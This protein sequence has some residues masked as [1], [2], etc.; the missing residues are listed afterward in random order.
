MKGVVIDIKYVEK[1]KRMELLW[2]I[3][4][5]IPYGIIGELFGCVAM[6][7]VVLQF[8]SILLLGKRVE[9]LNKV[10]HGFFAYIT[11]F[12]AYLYLLTDERPEIMPKI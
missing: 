9:I 2:R 1:T 5:M 11:Q 12:L 4:Y 3:L 7:C 6:I 10:T 8:L